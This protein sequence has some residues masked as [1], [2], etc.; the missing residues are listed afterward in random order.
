MGV[1]V[2]EEREGTPRYQVEL[3]QVPAHVV[4]CMRGCMAAWYVCRVCGGGC[5]HARD[6][7]CV[8]VTVCLEKT[9]IAVCSHLLTRA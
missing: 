7:V 4:V 5:V 6:H 9:Q 2:Y 3:F 1:C 8:T